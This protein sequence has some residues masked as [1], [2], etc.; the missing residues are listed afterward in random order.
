MGGM[1]RTCYYPTYIP[2]VVKECL[3]VPAPSAMPLES[4]ELM[5]TEV[6][7]I[8]DGNQMRI[9]LCVVFLF[10]LVY[11]EIGSLFTWLPGQPLACHVTARES[12]PDNL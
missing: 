6:C 1:R 2:Y 8:A 4:V 10:Y 7:G 12:V 3:Y 11:R 9:K 5:S